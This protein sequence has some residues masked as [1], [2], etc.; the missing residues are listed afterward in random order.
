[1][2]FTRKVKAAAADDSFTPETVQLADFKRVVLFAS[3]ETKAEK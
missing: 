3:A 1:M 2:P